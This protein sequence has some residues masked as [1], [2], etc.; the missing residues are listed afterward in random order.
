M[1]YDAIYQEVNVGDLVIAV[2][3][4]N[5]N[6]LGL[7]RVTEITFNFVI[8]KLVYKDM[9]TSLH[10]RR[11][12]LNEANVCNKLVKIKDYMTYNFQRKGYGDF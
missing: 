4:K 2:S 9:S 10:E 5:N 11:V 8:Y 3:E 12:R 1:F 6:K 7:F